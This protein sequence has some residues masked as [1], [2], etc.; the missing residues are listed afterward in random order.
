[1]RICFCREESS[2]SFI[3]N[4]SFGELGEVFP[5]V[6]EEASLVSFTCGSASQLNS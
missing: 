6:G 5:L 1:M 2:V 3:V 4:G